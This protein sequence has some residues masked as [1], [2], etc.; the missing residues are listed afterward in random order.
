MNNTLANGISAPKKRCNKITAAAKGLTLT[1]AYIGMTAIC[2]IAIMTVIHGIGRYAFGRPLTGNVELT[3]FNVVVGIFFCISYT[4]IKGEHV[5]VGMIVD[6]FPAKVQ[7]VFDIVMSAISLLFVVVAAYQTYLFV[8]D[9]SEEYSTVLFISKGPFLFIVAVGWTILALV[10]MFRLFDIVKQYAKAGWALLPILTGIAA[11]I[12]IIALSPLSAAV[13][14]RDPLTVG[15]IGVI[16]FVVVM[17]MK[18]P[19]A[20]AMGVT[21]LFGLGLYLGWGPAFN[22]LATIPFSSLY[23]YTWSTVP[24]F[25]TMGYLAKNSG[26]AEDFYYGVRQWMGHMKGGLLHAVIVG[27]GAF[28]ACS[29]DS[30]GAAVTF[31]SISL[32][33]TRKYGYDDGL[34]LG[35]IAGGSVLACIIPPSMMFIIYGSA[36]QT[37]IGKLFVGGILPGILLVLMYMIT[38]WLIV[39]RKPSLAP[40]TEK[41][42]MHARVKALPAMSFLILV[43]LIIIGGI[44]LGLFTPTEAGAFGVLA[45]LIIGLL[46]RRL[47][48]ASFKLSL[49]ESASTIGMVGLLL[50]GSMVLQRF[51]VL[52]GIPNAVADFMTNATSSPIAFM[53]VAG[54]V[55]LVL[56]TFIDALPLLL[57]VAPIFYPISVSY[58]ID[59]THFGIVCVVVIM[60]GTLTPPVGIALYALMGVAKDISLTVVIRGVLPFIFVMVVYSVLLIFFPQFSTLLVN[61]MFQS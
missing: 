47:T 46:R 36:T 61:L 2:L 19:V 58:G 1:C 45:V 59:P 28:G 60:I 54:L 56:G 13:K 43:F 57:L 21:G 31:C 40:A 42:T 18:L 27:N 3:N 14:S 6:R 25:V 37:S 7:G 53:I 30:I 12:L 5:A 15:I 26:L 35:C 39:T 23:N 20:I 44:Y 34:T 10:Y 55:L 24:M 49:K 33:E 32:P 52:T 29:G 17:F 48:W 22:S 50:A 38:I 11:G 4:L 41:T 16:I 8:P 51:I 9:F